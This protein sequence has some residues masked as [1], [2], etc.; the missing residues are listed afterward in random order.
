MSR[1]K[2]AHELGRDTLE[3]QDACIHDQCFFIFLC[4]KVRHRL[5]SVMSFSWGL[6]LLPFTME[7]M[8]DF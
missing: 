5:G 8:G 6:L 3:M 1:A 4:F 2:S 7:D